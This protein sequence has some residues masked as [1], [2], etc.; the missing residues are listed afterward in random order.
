MDVG[1]VFCLYQVSMT[2]T[3]GFAVAY[4]PVLHVLYGHTQSSYW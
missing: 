1:A 2:S 3:R 4:V